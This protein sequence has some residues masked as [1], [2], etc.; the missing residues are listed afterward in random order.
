MYVRVYSTQGKQLDEFQ[1]PKE[2]TQT[3]RIMLQTEGN[4]ILIVQ[5]P[6]YDSNRREVL[7]YGLNKERIALIDHLVLLSPFLGDIE[8]EYPDSLI[9]YE[10]KTGVLYTLVQDNFEL[11]VTA[12]KKD[13]ALYSSTVLGDYMDDSRL[14]LPDTTPL[15][16]NSAYEN[17]VGFLLNTQ[18]RTLQNLSIVQDGAS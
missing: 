9:H 2:L 13:K 18:K 11:Y 10:E 7:I 16:G 6:I 12:Q 17:I 3:S 8:S 1:L 5:E 4:H 15:S 14:D